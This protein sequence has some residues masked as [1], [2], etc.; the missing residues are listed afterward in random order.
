MGQAPVHR[1]LSASGRAAGGSCGKQRPR[2]FRAHKKLHQR[3]G[4]VEAAYPKGGVPLRVHGLIERFNE[5][6]L[7]K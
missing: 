3:R 6:S 5:E 7:P 1:Q 2:K 4:E